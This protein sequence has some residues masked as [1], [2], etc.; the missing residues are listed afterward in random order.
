[1]Q[2]ERT[3]TVPVGKMLP[4]ATAFAGFRI[5]LLVKR[6]MLKVLKIA[7]ESMITATLSC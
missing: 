5:E 1:M 4:I 6:T 2:F 7:E 3:V